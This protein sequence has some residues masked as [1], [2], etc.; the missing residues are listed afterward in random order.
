MRRRVVEDPA[1]RVEIPVWLTHLE[2]GL[3]H[4]GSVDGNG[5]VHLGRLD[6]LRA[7]EDAFL[8]EHSLERLP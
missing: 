7:L 4:V 2:L 6:R 8:R 5:A 1:T 3:R